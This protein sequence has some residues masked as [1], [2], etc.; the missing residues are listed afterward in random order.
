MGMAASTIPRKPRRE[1]RDNTARVHTS[2]LAATRPV[3][4]DLQALG[5]DIAFRL[6]VKKFPMASGAIGHQLLLS[7]SNVEAWVRSAGINVDHFF[8]LGVLS[9]SFDDPDLEAD[10]MC[11]VEDGRDLWVSTGSLRQV[12]DILIAEIARYTEI[13]IAPPDVPD[14][15]QL[16]IAI[17]GMTYF[18]EFVSPGLKQ[19]PATYLSHDPE[20]TAGPT[21]PMLFG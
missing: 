15:R 18:N 7:V 10:V 5:V 16:R 14:R 4:V 2:S 13:S 21:L 8:D 6:E 17:Y 1:R 19:L 9:F 3:T 12:W 11:R 20:A